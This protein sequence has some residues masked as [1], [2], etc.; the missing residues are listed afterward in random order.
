MGAWMCEGQCKI[1]EN[2][3]WFSGHDAVE[4]DED[5]VGICD[6]CITRRKQQLTFNFMEHEND[7]T[8]N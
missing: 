3:T 7:T 1:C 6:H 4:I 2:L 5:L 8:T